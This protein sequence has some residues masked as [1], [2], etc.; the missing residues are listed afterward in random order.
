MGVVLEIGKLASV[1][2]LHM[3]RNGPKLVKSY[4][5]AAVF[6]LM[7]VNSLGIFGYLSKAHIEQEVLN[8]T[9]SSSIELVMAKIDNE[10]SVIVDLDKQ[11][12]QIDNAIDKLTSQGK[13]QTSLQQSQVQRK[14]REKLFS[15]KLSHQEELGKLQTQKIAQ[16]NENKKLEADFGP[17]KY[18][19]DFIYGTANMVQLDVVVRWIIITLVMVFDPLALVLLNAALY[20]FSHYRE[21]RKST[22]PS[23]ADM[24]VM[25]L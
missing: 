20:T 23:S 19:A 10:K 18:L 15:E 5:I 1:T 22:K 7:L 9:K 11:I 2:Y 12:A 17:L 13:A 8:T 4:L 16:D 3:I 25:E 6:T 24:M 21:R 14:Q